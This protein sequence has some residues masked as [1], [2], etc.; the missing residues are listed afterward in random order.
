MV[1]KGPATREEEKEIKLE[2]EIKLWNDNKVEVTNQWDD[3]DH[4][5]KRP[6]AAMVCE[7]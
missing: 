4:P 5:F 2:G 7:T 3:L 6:L 1:G